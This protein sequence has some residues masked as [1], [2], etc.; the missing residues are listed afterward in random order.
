M[1]TFLYILILTAIGWT[2][3]PTNVTIVCPVDSLASTSDSIN[4]DSLIVGRVSHFFN[5]RNSDEGNTFDWVVDLRVSQKYNMGWNP[6]FNT[7][8]STERDKG[9]RHNA[10]LVHHATDYY[11]IRDRVDTEHKLYLFEYGVHYTWLDI[12]HGYSYIWKSNYRSEEHTLYHSYESDWLKAEIQYLNKIYKIELELSID[13]RWNVKSD[14][15]FIKVSTKYLNIY[16]RDDIWSVG[17]SLGYE[18]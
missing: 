12:K 17:Y 16:D 13:K 15:I 11:F 5:S 3:I 14:E 1:R 6:E 8:V 4:C 7:Q 10:Y 9:E 2:D 18:W